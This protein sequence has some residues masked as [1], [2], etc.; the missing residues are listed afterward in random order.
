MQAPIDV[1]A[2][3]LADRRRILV[4]TGAG[5]ST[6]S[7]IPDFR[8]PDGIWTKIDPNDFTIHRYLESAEVRRRSWAMWGGSQYMA[9]EPNAGHRAIVRLWQQ[10]RLAGCVTQNIDGLHAA[11]GLPEH[12]IAELHG[13]TRAVSCLECEARWETEVVLERVRAGET[14]PKCPDCGGIIKLAVISFGQMLPAREMLKAQAMAEMADAVVA[15]GTTLSVWPAAD[16]PLTVAGRGHPFV[17]I[18][19]GETE[20]DSDAIKIES[21]AGDALTALADRLSTA[22]GG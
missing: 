3:A 5:I 4:F 16:I 22:A 14:D 2:A 7:G 8:G 9:A 10:D 20:F 17:I 15:V 13:N 18:N 12:A 1:A 21:G 11:A 6:E 19:Q